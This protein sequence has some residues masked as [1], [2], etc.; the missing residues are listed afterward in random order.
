VQ[1]ARRHVVRRED[2]QRSLPGELLGGDIAASLIQR[3]ATPA[4]RPP[5]VGRRG[6]QCSSPVRS[7]RPRRGLY[8]GDSPTTSSQ[9]AEHRQPPGRRLTCA[10]GSHPIHSRA[11]WRERAPPTDA[12][13][14]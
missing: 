9:R 7:P 1:Q 12:H 13:D 2:V 14:D 4:P 6:V 10:R 8:S 5:P 3:E 11:G